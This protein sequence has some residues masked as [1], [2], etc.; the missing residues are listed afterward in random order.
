MGLQKP[1]H[2]QGVKGAMAESSRE[3]M[4]T[5]T[6]RLITGIHGERKRVVGMIP[7]VM[8]AP[9]RRQA[10]IGVINREVKLGKR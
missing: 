10:R 7:V 9:G 4:Q 1:H 8:V 6:V 2:H 5:D 3:R